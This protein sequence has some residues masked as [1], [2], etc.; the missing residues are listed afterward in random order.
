M[1]VPG[2]AHVAVWGNRDR[3]LQ[4]LVDPEKL[5]EKGV[6]L[7]QIIETTGNALWV[8]PL[9][10]LEASSPGSAGFIDTP[11][12][13]LTVWH[14]LPI[15][16]PEELAKV[17]VEGTDGLFL[18]DV[19]KVVE[20]HQPLIGD[21]V[22][23]DSANPLLVVEK[24][25]EV[26]TLEVTR[27]VE[28][29]L[30]ALQ[31]G[32]PGINFDATLFRP[33]TYIEMALA[34]LTQSLIIAALLVVLILGAF[35]YGWRT[36]LISLMAIVVSLFAALFV[37]YLRGSTLNSMV[38]AGLVIALGVVVDDAV[39]DV[40]NIRRRLRQNR[41]EGGLRPAENVILAASAEMRSSIFFA[42]FITLLAIV[43]VF[44]MEGMSSALFQLMAI[45]YALAVLTAM[46]VALTVTPALS[47]MLLAKRQ[48][49]VSESPLITRLQNGYERALEKIEI[50]FLHPP[51]STS[52]LSV[53][54]S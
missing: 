2:V 11:N 12:Q 28:Q 52:S 1:G 36:A 32:M 48:L 41:Q 19:T 25:P 27:D 44:F 47:F 51:N 50:G 40:E 30:A 49:N 38:L 13:R 37:L 22:I 39:V 9:T 43:P 20:D 3:Q 53:F 31:P 45:S 15:S 42:T 8:S 10:F 17:P 23:N 54:L 33:T 34:N 16:S 26:N 5:Q 35:L 29:A 6:T 24:L 7:D 4:V 21:A 18:G 14:V 46:V